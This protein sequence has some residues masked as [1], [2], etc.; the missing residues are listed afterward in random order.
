MNPRGVKKN[1]STVD[2]K[3]TTNCYSLFI[4]RILI[5]FFKDGPR[6]PSALDRTRNP[7]LQGYLDTIYWKGGGGVKGGQLLKI[8]LSERVSSKFFYA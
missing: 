7:R 6:G 3:L 2:F 8:I 5:S 4:Y 1:Q